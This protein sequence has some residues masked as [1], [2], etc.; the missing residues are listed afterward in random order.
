M[1]LLSNAVKFTDLGRVLVRAGVAR[2]DDSSVVVRFEVSD[3]GIGI[4]PQAQQRIFDAFSQADETDDSPLWRYGSGLTICRN[5]VEMMGGEI[6]VTSQP[7]TGSTFWC[8]IPFRAGT[9]PTPSSAPV[10]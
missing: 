4:E 9:T 6:G 7:G 3:T 1:N 2:T 8:E 5:L 10:A